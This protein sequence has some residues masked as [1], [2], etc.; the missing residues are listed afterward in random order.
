MSNNIVLGIEG[1]INITGIDGSTDFYWHAESPEPAANSA[2]KY[3]GAVRARLGYAMDRFMPYVAGGL[4]VAQYD[5][6]LIDDGDLEFADSKTLAGW[7]IGA[8]VEYAATDNLFLRAEYRYA[9]FGSKSFDHDFADGA[10]IDLP[11]HDI[12]IGLAWKF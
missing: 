4:S 1:D 12:R 3:S 5:F 9:D 11:T 7:N 10:K 2:M 6:N 8:G